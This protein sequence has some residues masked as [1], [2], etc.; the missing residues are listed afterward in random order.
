MVDSRRSSRRDL[1]VSGDRRT[2]AW[3]TKAVADGLF[4]RGAEI[5]QFDQVY[6][7]R[8]EPCWSRDHGHCPGAGRDFLAYGRRIRPP[9]VA[10]GTTRHSFSTERNKSDAD[11]E[12]VCSAAYETLDGKR[13]ALVL[14]NATAEAQTATWI[15]QGELTSLRLAPD[16]IRIVEFSGE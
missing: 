11:V 12:A 10:C 3:W 4:A 1:A 5:I 13:R 16:E 7:G 8:H 9:K 14:V 6:G 2:R 15:W